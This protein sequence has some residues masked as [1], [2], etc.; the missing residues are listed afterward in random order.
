LH[1]R[2]A[3]RQLADRSLGLE[4]EVGGRASAQRYVQVDVALALGAAVLD[5][6][7]EDDLIRR[8]NLERAQRRIEIDAGDGEVVLYA[9]GSG[10]GGQVGPARRRRIDQGYP[11]TPDRYQE[12]GRQHGRRPPW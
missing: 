7:Q 9:G 11:T 8:A 5:H 10:G 6:H 4:E 1:A 2:L 12:Q 3:G